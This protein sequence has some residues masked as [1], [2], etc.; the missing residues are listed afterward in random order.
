MLNEATDGRL[1]EKGLARVVN[2]VDRGV[3]GLDL[4]PVLSPPFYLLVSGRPPAS[5]LII[6]LF[7]NTGGNGQRIV[8][9]SLS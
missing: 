4:G 1:G 2:G 8:R 3:E 6:D 7:D 9:H 5:L